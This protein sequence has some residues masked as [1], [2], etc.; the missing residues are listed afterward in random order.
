MSILAD[1]VE[2]GDCCGAQTSMIQSVCL[3][4]GKIMMGRQHTI[5]AANVDGFNSILGQDVKR[6]GW[7]PHQ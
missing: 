5:G 4:G 1:F 6:R 2:K 7:R 3:I